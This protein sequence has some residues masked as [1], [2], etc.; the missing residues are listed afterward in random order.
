M[1]SAFAES[2]VFDHPD[3]TALVDWR[4]TSI[5]LLTYSAWDFSFDA[6]AKV[7]VIVYY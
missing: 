6:F 4:K 5:Y 7:L 2:S 3:I 1:F